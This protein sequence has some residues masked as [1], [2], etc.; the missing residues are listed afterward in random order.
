MKFNKNKHKVL[1]IGRNNEMRRYNDWL[2]CSSSE[3]EVVFEMEHTHA[4][5]KPM[6]YCCKKKKIANTALMC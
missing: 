4:E 2:A 5:Y 6:Q 1:Y 3:K